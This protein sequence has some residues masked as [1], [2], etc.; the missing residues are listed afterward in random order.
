MNFKWCTIQVKNME[1]SLKFY[2]DI[3]RLPLKQKFQ[4]E[5]GIQIVVLGDGETKV[6]LIYN[7]NEAA[8]SSYQGI[9]LA[10]EVKDLDKMIKFVTDKGISIQSGPFQPNPNMKFFYI[11]DPDGVKIQFVESL[12]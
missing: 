11:V 5:D 7:A 10:F 4:P 2:Q 3:V 9:A 12:K 1:D 6:E 8:I